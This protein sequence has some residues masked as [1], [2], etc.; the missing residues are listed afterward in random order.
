MGG[1]PDE[2]DEE[3]SRKSKIER[4][5]GLDMANPK[6]SDD[7]NPK[8][9]I[10]IADPPGRNPKSTKCRT[11]GQPIDPAAS[12]FP[13]CSNRCRLADLGTWFNEGYRVSRP[14]QAQEEDEIPDE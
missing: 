13:F 14:V 9:K 1:L 12:T 6:S 2:F 10:Q 8:S 5:K 4:R 7:L 11:C 3:Q